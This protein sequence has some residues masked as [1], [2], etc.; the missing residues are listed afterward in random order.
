M[1]D[2]NPIAALLNLPAGTHGRVTI[3][4]R[5]YE[6]HAASPG[7]AEGLYRWNPGYG[8]PNACFSLHLVPASHRAMALG[9][10][11]AGRHRVKRAEAEAITAAA[12]AS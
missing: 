3:A 7:T 2:L 9:Q 4:G 11:L 6:Y 8:M 10:Y 1:T 12:R 5:D